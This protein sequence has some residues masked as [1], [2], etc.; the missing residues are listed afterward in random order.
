MGAKYSN[1]QLANPLRFLAADAVQ[2]ASSGHPG[3]PM[4]MA[5]I[6]TVLWREFLSHNPKDP[7]WHNRDRFVL[8]NGHGS[9]LQYALLHLSGYGLSIEDIKNFRQFK[10]PTPGHPELETIGVETT[11]GPLG[12]G[13]AN[14]VGMAIAERNLAAEFNRPQFDLI[15]HYTYVFAGDGCLMEGISHEACSLAGTQKL[16][17]LICFFDDNGISIDGKVE[18]WCR[19]NVK[20]RFTAYGWQV[21]G[22][23]SG[24]NYQEIRES[25]N[26]AK[27]SEFPSL[28]ICKTHIGYGSPNK[29]DSAAAHG[30]PLGEEEIT[31]VRK[32]LSWNYPPFVI[33]EEIYS[34]WD[35]RPQGEKMQEQWNKLYDEYKLTYPRE[36]KEYR[37]RMKGELPEDFSQQ[38]LDLIN[39]QNNKEASLASR[40]ASLQALNTLVPVLPEL[41]GGSADLSGSNCSLSE[42]SVALQ[43]DGN[44]GNYIYYGVRELAMSAIMNGISL[45]GGYIAYGGTFLVFL[46]YSRSAIRLA[47]LMK[48]KVIF[49]FSHD[50]IGIGEDGPTHQP[51]EH[52]SILRSTPNIDTWRPSDTVECAVAW[53]Q[54]LQ[55]PYP[56]ALILSR[57]KLQFQQRTKEQIDNIAKGGYVLIEGSPD[58]AK[59]HA[60]VIATGSE[61]NSARE[62]VIKYNKENSLRNGNKQ[63]RLVSIPC[64]EVFDGQTQEYRDSVLPPQISNR[65]AV[66]AARP[67]YWCRYTG[68]HGK[69]MG[70]E[71]FGSSAPADELFEHF[72]LTAEKIYQSISDFV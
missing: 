65:L 3:M 11:T 16:G 46:D 24:H 10:S 69:V 45:H 23:I 35:A 27:Q 64:C 63:V 52:L 7:N 48:R 72:G 58:I 49:I 68:L 4:G 66:E 37:R 13:L 1:S 18:N 36:E 43:D 47:A 8:S 32:E 61:L 53:T 2:H 56:S 44:Y 25:I 42:H 51:I 50:S 15:A 9:M 60:L 5:D 20:Q 33:P 29:V 67:E 14:A 12:Q 34:D 71:S 54:A 30:A 39:S 59:L 70:I 6:A 55:K 26:Q 28:I 38:S 17:K 62:A 22:P 21:I 40:Q 31:L 41:I 57:Q 19:D